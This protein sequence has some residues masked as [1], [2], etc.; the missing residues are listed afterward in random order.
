MTR[1]LWRTLSAL[2]PERAVR[3]ELRAIAGEQ[4]ALRR[5][6]A[7]AAGG[8]APGAMFAAVAQEAGRVLPEADFT[9]VSRYD[10]CRRCRGGRR[11][12][13]DRAATCS[14]AAGRSSADR[15]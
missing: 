8:A 5:V 9:I 1:L 11:L 12:E 3:V 4:A 13:Q 6:A 14:P 10:A 15:T 2:G 7:L